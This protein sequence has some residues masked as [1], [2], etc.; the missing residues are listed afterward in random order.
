MT[1]ARNEKRKQV[2]TQYVTNKMKTSSLKNR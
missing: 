1:N 2:K